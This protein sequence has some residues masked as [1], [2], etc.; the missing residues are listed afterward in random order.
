MQKRL[1]VASWYYQVQR[2]NGGGKEKWERRPERGRRGWKGE[3]AKM[4]NDRGVLL[5]KFRL[6]FFYP[7]P[8]VLEVLVLTLSTI[9]FSPLLTCR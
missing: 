9:I 8:T 5:P 2:E 3:G 7:F 6:R 4:D 1:E